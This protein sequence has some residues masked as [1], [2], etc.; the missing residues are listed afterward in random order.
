[1]ERG[2]EE[3]MDGDEWHD[4]KV[5]DW[6]NRLGKAFGKTLNKEA[7]IFTEALRLYS[8][9]AYDRVFEAMVNDDPSRAEEMAQE[10]VNPDF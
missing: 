5:K 8:Q 10:A 4:K 9:T 3:M 2:E 7:D 1:M 6:V